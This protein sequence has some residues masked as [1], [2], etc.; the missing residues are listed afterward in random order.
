MKRYTLRGLIHDAKIFNQLRLEHREAK[1]KRRKL[2]KDLKTGRR[3]HHE[4]TSPGS[5]GEILRRIAAMW[6][7]QAQQTK[8]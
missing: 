4:K 6:R 5:G 1:K 2:Q 7:K 3:L 8:L